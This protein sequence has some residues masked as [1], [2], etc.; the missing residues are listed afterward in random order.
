MGVRTRPVGTCK[1]CA[2][3]CAEAGA[4]DA[5]QG[6]GEAG[7]PQPE[8]PAPMFSPA[9]PLT[10]VMVIDGSKVRPDAALTYPHFIVVRVRLYRVS[11]VRSEEVITQLLVPRSRR[12]MVFQAAHY[13][14]M[15]GYLGYDKTLNRIMARFYWPGIRA[16]VRRW[17]ASCPEYQL[18]NP[19]AFPRAPLRPL[20]LVKAPFDRIGMDI[21]GQFERSAHGYRFV[22]VLID[23]ATRYPEEIP[24]R[25]I[26]AKSVAQALFHVISR[27]GIPK[28]ILTR[29]MT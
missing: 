3:F 18:V 13:N 19:P 6:S 21:I 20:P 8:V 27:V 25:N 10:Q 17:C 9:V 22:L 26:S 5:A 14:P 16:E 11:R 1:S 28:E 12:E 4:D 23:Y 29:D 24:L 7:D 15:A 2:V